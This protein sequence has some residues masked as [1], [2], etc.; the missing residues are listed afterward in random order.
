MKKKFE[1]LEHTADVK[2]R[3]YGKNL[4]EIFSN[5]ASAISHIL[6]RGNKVKKKI[7]YKS[8]I[9]GEDKESLLYSFIDEML[10]LFDAEHFIVSSAKVKINAYGAEIL[11]YGDNSLK[12]KDLDSIKAATYAEMYIREIKKGKWEAQVVVDV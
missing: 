3:I 4:N 9:S 7:T 6:S 2:F 10:Y 1:F 8:Y 5:C 12:Y 11:F